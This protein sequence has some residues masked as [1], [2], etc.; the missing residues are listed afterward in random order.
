MASLLQAWPP[1]FSSAELE[2]LSRISKTYALTNSLIIKPSLSSTEAENTATHAPFCLLPS[3]FPRTQFERAVRIQ[4]DYNKLYASISTSPALIRE[5]IGKIVS[6]VDPFIG[7]LY[8][9]WEMLELERKDDDH[10]SLG[11][12][13]SDYLL[14]YPSSEGS[15]G[16]KQVEFNTI[17]VSFGCLANKVSGLHRY[18]TSSSKAYMTCQLPT[19]RAIETLAKG[20]TIAHQTY[21]SKYSPCVPVI[22]MM[23]VQPNERNLFDQTLLEYELDAQPAQIRLIRISYRDILSLTEIDPHS[24]KLYYISPNGRL[25]VS[26]VYYRCMYGPEDFT[27]ECDWQARYQLERSRAIN[28]PNLSTQLAGC[29]IIQQVLTDKNFIERHLD[30]TQAGLDESQWEELSSTWMKIFPLNAEGYRLANDPTTAVDFV[31]KPQREGGGNN[32][33]GNDIP[34]FL[35]SLSE[36]NRPAYILMSRIQT[37]KGVGNYLIRGSDSKAGLASVEVVSELGIFGVCLFKRKQG[38]GVEILENF[39]AGHSVR[40]KNCKDDEGGVAVGISCLDSP[41]LISC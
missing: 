26:V 19:N 5:V 36:E 27:T 3:P 15:S 29:K 8:Q 25:E 40:T 12:F 33:Y 6:K 11:I 32:I 34:T 18:L 38:G 24:L 13:R 4:V 31:L 22:I 16:I 2:N 35:R 41:L 23:I 10:L 14:H 37:P 28:C 21:S 1:T 17:S 9:Y 30:L 7:K 20:L 39:Q